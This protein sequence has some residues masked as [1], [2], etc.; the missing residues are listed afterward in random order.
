MQNTT[1]RIFQ[2]EYIFDMGDYHDK[3]LSMAAQYL[4]YLGTSDMTPEEVK[5]AF[6]DMAC[7]FS[8]NPGNERTYLSLSGLH[9]NMPKAIAL[10]EKLL[11]IG[12]LNCQ[13]ML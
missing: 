13:S 8:V 5:R 4:E 7:G 3:A 10:F 11:S 6:Y 1:N 9:E 12:M 2:L